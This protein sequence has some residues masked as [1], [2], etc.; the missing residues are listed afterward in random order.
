MTNELAVI[1][2]SINKLVQKVENNNTNQNTGKKN[3]K[4]MKD[5]TCIKCG[6]KGHF[7]WDCIDDKPDGKSSSTGN[8]KKPNWHYVLPK[9]GEHTKKEDLPTQNLHHGR[10]A[11]VVAHLM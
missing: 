11:T 6:K 9:K 7:G 3:K 8:T 4:N 5:V 1:K 2:A 10:Q